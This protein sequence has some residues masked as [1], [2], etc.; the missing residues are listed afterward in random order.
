[1][2]KA[3][4]NDSSLNLLDTFSS[5]LIKKEVSI[6]E[7]AESSDYC[8]K[9]LYPRQ[10]VVLKL[11]FLEELDGYEEDVLNEWIRSTEESGEVIIAP[12]IR[13]RITWLR[14]HNY[15]HFTIN[16]LV[17]GRRSGKGYMTGAAIAYKLHKLI[18]LDNPGRHFG[19]EQGHD[20]YTTIV[21][22][23]LEQAKTIQFKDAKS[24]ILDCKALQP[25]IGKPLAESISVYTPYDLAREQDLY[26]RGI[27]TEGELASLRVQAFAKNARTI[28][29]N[30]SIVLVFDEHA[31]ITPGE[32]HI[33]DEELFKAAEPS[34]AQF[35]MDAMIFSNSSPYQK[36]GK[37]FSLYEDALKLD[38]EVPVFMTQFMLQ[39]PSW[40]MYKDWERDRKFTRAI[41]VP[42]HQSIS[43]QE[44]EKANPESF[45]VEYRA[46]FA[47]VLEA[48]L[49]P[50]YVDRMFD[51]EFTQSILG[52]DLVPTHGAVGYFTY[53]G[54]GDPSSTT[55]NFGVA[56]GHVEPVFNSRTGADEAHVVF[57]FIDAFYPEDF[58][59][60]TIDW[61]EIH[62]AIMDI[63]NAFRPFEFTF[64]QFDTTKPVQDI[65]RDLAKLGIND[66]QVYVKTATNPTN[67]RRWDAFKAALNLGRIHAPHP[68][69]NMNP[70]HNSLELA[71]NELK[72]LQKK[73]NR[74]VKQDIGPIQTKDM[75]DCIAEVVD[76][77]I[78]DT[79]E[80]ELEALS[81]G[82]AV[83][84]PGGYSIGNR[85]T[86]RTS[87]GTPLE[88]YY[89]D[90]FARQRGSGIMNP[91]ARLRGR[92]R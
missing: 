23:S 9:P 31:H 89:D 59:D 90:M 8:H 26:A 46:Q 58:P 65:V 47:E 1:M 18:Q 11:M 62:P 76:A 27:K 75:A 28:R 33:S 54:H 84:A 52:R 55:A 35:D 37:F 85:A 81:G 63:I 21:A 44:R 71:R 86:H 10:R 13:E 51:P 12:K 79:I 73:N 72:F 20:I 40:E 92:R 19:V 74:V 49:N 2:N 14:D 22:D 36:T 30:A 38:N 7:F 82:L 88:G 56:V 39:Y 15:P 60:H 80:G 34:L 5:S 25:Y 24:W 66:T 61:N 45:R 57:D 50:F 78:G 17:G 91:L 77:L 64:D 69:H 6:I 3:V 68:A 83:G 32:S 4:F 43:L 87:I 42:P 48:F 53:K 29:G 70:S 41:V 67:N 16:Q